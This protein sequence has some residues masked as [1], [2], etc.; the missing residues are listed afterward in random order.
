VRGVIEVVLGEHLPK[1][2]RREEV[3][4]RRGIKLEVVQDTVYIS[5]PERSWIRPW[6]WCRRR[7][8]RSCWRGIYVHPKEG[9]LHALRARTRGLPN[10][11]QT[12][13]ATYHERQ[14]TSAPLWP[15]GEGG[16]RPPP[17]LLHTNRAINRV[18]R[19][20]PRRRRRRFCALSGQIGTHAGFQG[21]RAH[22][23]GLSTTP[24]SDGEAS[25]QA[26]MDRQG[27]H[28]FDT[29]LGQAPRPLA[30]ALGG[31]C[32]GLPRQRGCP[33]YHGD[34]FGGLRR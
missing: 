32:V 34:P 10:T 31:L 25:T 27:P 14:A 15:S 28:F 6:R 18:R 11:Y 9:I 19:K 12:T 24:G 5:R 16:R 30:W 29:G 7:H 1:P 22:Q 8:Q 26:F 2:T 3:A 33:R 23:A 13:R 21:Y 17:F 20:P 4:L